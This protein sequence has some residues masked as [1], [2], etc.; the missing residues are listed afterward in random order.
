[1]KSY[2]IITKQLTAIR[3]IA[4]KNMDKCPAHYS[5]VVLAADETLAEIKQLQ[6]QAIEDLELSL[7]YAY[8]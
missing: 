3:A 5:M 4:I 6:L 2:K 7:E 8:S 1:M